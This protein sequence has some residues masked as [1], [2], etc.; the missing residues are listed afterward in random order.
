MSLNLTLSGIPLLQTPTD[1]TVRLVVKPKKLLS[2]EQIL[3]EYLKFVREC[4][5]LA[6]FEEDGTLTQVREWFVQNPDKDPNDFWTD[7]GDFLGYKLT[8][9]LTGKFFYVLRDYFDH[10]LSCKA[11]LNKGKTFSYT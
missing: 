6:Y 3:A 1:L 7:L 5:G 8:S 10:E 11:A 4:Y 2:Q 9:L